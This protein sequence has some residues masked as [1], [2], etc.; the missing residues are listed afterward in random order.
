M[1]ERIICAISASATF[2]VNAGYAHEN[3]TSVDLKKICE[4]CKKVA[5][6]VMEQTGIYVSGT[7]SEARTFYKTDWGC[8]VG[9]EGTFVLMADCNPIFRSEDMDRH[10]Y[11]YTW[12][13][14]FLA[15]VRLLKAELQQTTVLAK[16]GPIAYYFTNDDNS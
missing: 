13:K 3:E 9:G 16:V 2:G 6:E 1:E 12:I 15:M 4:L 14:A 11:E 5:D 8:P 10:L 7:V